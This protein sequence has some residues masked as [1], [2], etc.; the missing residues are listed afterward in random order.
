MVP[1]KTA[2]LAAVSALFAL[3]VRAQPIPAA[4]GATPPA[5]QVVTFDQMQAAH[6]L[7]RTLSATGLGIVAAVGAMMAAVECTDVADPRCADVAGGKPNGQE[8]LLSQGTVVNATAAGES[9]TCLA[10]GVH[11][12]CPPPRELTQ[13]ERDRIVQQARQDQT[14]GANSD[15]SSRQPTTPTGGSTSSDSDD[16]LRI[17]SRGNKE[18]TLPNGGTVLPNNG[19]PT[20]GSTEGSGGGMNGFTAD[21]RRIVSSDGSTTNSFDITEYVNNTVP[22]I[23]ATQDSVNNMIPGSQTGVVNTGYS[24]AGG[25]KGRAGRGGSIAGRQTGGAQIVKVECDN[26]FPEL[27]QGAVNINSNMADDFQNFN[28]N[29]NR[30]PDDVD[31]SRGTGTKGVMGDRT[32]D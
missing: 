8:T 20:D 25:G 31:T 32:G 7:G 24:A 2:A 9:V 30:N 23:T 12:P 3:N 22:Q 5:S 4:G 6:E 28:A 17:A 18:A 10:P 14:L 21:G 27:C 29:L 19:M 11:G 1:S 16:F 26:T 13:A 15:R